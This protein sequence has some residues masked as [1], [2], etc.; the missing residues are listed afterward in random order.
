MSTSVT[1][2]EA[3][4]EAV[5]RAADWNRAQSFADFLPTAQKNADL[6]RLTYERAR[7]PAEVVARVEGFPGQWRLLVLSEDW[8]GDAANTVPVLAAFADAAQNVELRLLARD[9]NPALMD[10]HLTNGTSRSIP[11]VMVLDGS[12][13]EHGWWGPR[14][15]DLQAWVLTEGKALEPD[16]RY[17]EIRKWYARD[18]GLTTLHE[19][20][21]LI[22]RTVGAD[23]P[24]G[25]A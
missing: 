1:T 19:V 16:D 22:A 20:L 11:V 6:W 8:C 3:T 18:K 2:H 7:I 10:E 17:R 4:A 14:P 24:G 9:E 5:S 13:E 25:P 12:G 15:A 23:R 21:G